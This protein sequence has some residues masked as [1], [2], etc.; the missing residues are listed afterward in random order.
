MSW[1]YILRK[2]KDPAK[3][4]RI[5]VERLTEPVH[6]NVLSLFVALFGTF[7]AKVA[8]DLVVRQQYAFCLLKAAELAKSQ[9]FR[10]VTAIEFGVAAGA[11]L[12][13]MCEIAHKVERATGVH[14]TVVGFDSGHGLPPP[15]DFRDHPERFSKADYPMDSENLLSSLPNNAELILGDI[16]ETLPA[17]ITTLSK[18]QPLA[19]VA[20]DVDYY[21][22]AT[23]C[24]KVFLSSDP[25]K[26]LPMTML[27]LDDIQITS[28]N[29][30][31][32]ELLAV[33]EFNSLET[34]R[35]I[36]LYPSLR[37]QRIFKGTC[38]IE[39]VYIMHALDHPLRTGSIP[40]YITRTLENPYLK[41][42]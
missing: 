31:C 11:G 28:A 34:L 36:S 3:L 10:K 30:W 15:L 12:L 17:F 14:F 41:N 37:T 7:R 33:Q 25:E 19:F 4:R 21:S 22:S 5:F 13:N 39:Q 18:D 23:E 35:K 38:W 27:Y 26:Y 29:P 2:V 9:G 40:N 20:L 8:F 42:S 16:A 24:L 1:N 32:G 6:L